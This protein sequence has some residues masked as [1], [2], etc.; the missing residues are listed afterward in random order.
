[1][2]TAALSTPTTASGPAPVDGLPKRL[3]RVLF[4]TVLMTATMPLIVVPFP[5]MEMWAWWAVFAALALKIG[6]GI[7]LVLVALRQFELAA[8]P[9]GSPALQDPVARWVLAQSDRL[10]RWCWPVWCLAQLVLLFMPIF[11]TLYLV[12]TALR[13]LYVT[14]R[15]PQ[16][17]AAGFWQEA[18]LTLRSLWSTVLGLFFLTVST[19]LGSG[20]AL[21]TL[22]WLVWH[23]PR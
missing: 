12:V 15:Q 8:F 22:A 11:F 4:G 3:G 13:P 7:S 21:A 18:R 9:P 19:L 1:M 6:L 14:L 5:G 23:A 16:P 17:T 20:S 2:D 10:W